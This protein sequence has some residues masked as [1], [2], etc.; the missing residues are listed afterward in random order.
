MSRND[1]AHWS[2]LMRRAQGG[3][4]AAY[5]QLLAEL[6]EAIAG[7]IRHRFG[8]VTFAEDC[9]QDCLIAVHEARHTFM[10]GRPLRPW[11]FAIVRNRTIDLLRRQRREAEMFPDRF[12]EAAMLVPAPQERTPAPERGPGSVLQALE[13]RHR[14]ALLLTKVMGFSIAEAAGRLGISTGAMKVRVHR[15]TR[16][17]ARKLEAERE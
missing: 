1:E 9:V 4:A 13:P 8:P 5:E 7:Y 10:P 3:D 14:E 17:A 2:E 6:A 15:A 16:A 11:L 12:E